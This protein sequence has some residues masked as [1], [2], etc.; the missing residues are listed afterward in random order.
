MRVV[1]GDLEGAETP[2]MVGHYA[3]D[4]I[5]N[6]EAYLDRQLDGRL[7]EAQP[8]C[9]YSRDWRGEMLAKRS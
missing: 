1:H 4:S 7:Q 9:F 2:V 6:A 5:V 8:C 3:G